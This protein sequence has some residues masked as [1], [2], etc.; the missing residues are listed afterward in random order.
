MPLFGAKHKRN[1]NTSRLPFTLAAAVLAIT[2]VGGLLFFIQGSA[3]A[4]YQDAVCEYSGE[5][6]SYQVQEDDTLLSVSNR[7]GISVDTLG[8]A[9][10]IDSPTDLS[11]GQVLTI[12]VP[13]PS[14]QQ[15]DTRSVI[16][17]T[18]DIAP[19]EV[20][21]TEMIEV[22]FR[23]NETITVLDAVCCEEFI[24]GNR[25]I[26]AI[27]EGVIIEEQ[28]LEN[29]V[30]SSI[31]NGLTFDE[32][33]SPMVI[34]RQD[35]PL[36]AVITEDMLLTVLVPNDFMSELQP[37]QSSFM[38]VIG[39]PE[40]AIGQ[41][42]TALIRQ[43]EPVLMENLSPA[44]DCNGDMSCFNLQPGRVAF[45][46]TTDDTNL[47]NMTPGQSVDILLPLQLVQIQ[48]GQLEFRHH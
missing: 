22:D 32:D 43:Y 5:H 16:V 35:I 1:Q 6:H 18:R 2:I 39:S 25:V 29:I 12:P 15:N 11:A 41:Q 9:N 4:P 24:V 40:L 38:N 14:E 20:I 33:Y 13:E 42:A 10:C 31:E 46:L 27:E 48:E 44:N 37:P 23:E 8:D 47:L 30:F 28:M 17:T 21:T 3:D 36:N 26:E 7:F 19:G 45:A 34:A